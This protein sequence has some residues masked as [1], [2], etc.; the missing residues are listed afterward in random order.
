MPR[1]FVLVV[2]FSV[3]DVLVFGVFLGIGSEHGKSL[4]HILTKLMSLAA[5]EAQKDMI[6][7]TLQVG[8]FSSA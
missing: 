3:F 8:A 2:F 4:F 1:L 7:W 5:L 6:K